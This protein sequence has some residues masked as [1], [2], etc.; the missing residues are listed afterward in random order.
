M[1]KIDVV[2]VLHRYIDVCP[3]CRIMTRLEAFCISLPTLDETRNLADEWRKSFLS[4]EPE[5]LSFELLG[6]PEVTANLYCN[7]AYPYWEGC[8]ICSIYLR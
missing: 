2:I 1:E 3:I 5:A 4:S 6:D 7:F 8:V